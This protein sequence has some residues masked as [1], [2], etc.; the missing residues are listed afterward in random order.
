M[1]TPCVS[2]TTGAVPEMI[3]HE[4]D[5]LLVEPRDSKAVADAISRLLDDDEFRQQLGYRA[6]ETMETKFGLDV[7]IDRLT[8]SFEKA[9]VDR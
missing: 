6:R 1:E 9:M 5:G 8:T 7:V 2:T 3:T 4:H